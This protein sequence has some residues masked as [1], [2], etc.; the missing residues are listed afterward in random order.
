M[1]DDTKICFN[2]SCLLWTRKVQYLI[3]KCPQL[4]FIVR[5]VN[6]VNIV[7]TY[8][9]N[10]DCILNLSSTFSGFPINV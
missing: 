4:V 1:A 8:F 5:Y 2:I 9:L 6:L 3:K 10:T 7:K